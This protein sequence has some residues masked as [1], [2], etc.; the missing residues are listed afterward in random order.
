M[1]KQTVIVTGANRGIGLAIV[2]QFAEK[3]FDIFACAR[4]ETDEFVNIIEELK[5]KYQV[6]IMPIYFDLEC[7]NEVKA[8]ARKI[9]SITKNINVLVNN[10]GISYSGL[11]NMTSIDKLKEV[12]QINFFSQVLFT[13]LIS[14]AMIRQNSGCIINMASVGGIEAKPGYM[15]YGSSKAAVIWETR[16]LAAELGQY[17]I[18]V[19][20]VAPGLVNTDMG[21]VKSENEIKKVLNRTP[22]SRMASRDEVAKTV[23]FLASEDASFITGEILKVDGGRCC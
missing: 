4:K 2:N 12:F 15:A 22:L 11:F 20:A 16:C 21:Y 19:N 7:E 10:A 14:R 18:R 5:H 23:F 13:Q 17:N 3:G 9:L 1:G 8:G 6:E